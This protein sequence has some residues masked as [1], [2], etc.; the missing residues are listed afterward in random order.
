MTHRSLF[1]IVLGSAFAL[2]ALGCGDDE[3]GGSGT[4]GSGNAATGGS[5]NAATGGSGNAATGGSGNAATGGGATGGS[6][7][8][9][10]GSFDCTADG[11][12]GACIACM[13]SSCC[14]E[15]KACADDDTCTTCLGCIEN[16]QSIPNCAADCPVSNM[17]TSDSSNCA[18]TDCTADCF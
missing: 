6:N 17:P 4:G 11:N 15:L 16:M 7:T 5:G 18:V 8:G 9:G 3:S 12:D 10:G 13:K 2:T 1:A 14:P